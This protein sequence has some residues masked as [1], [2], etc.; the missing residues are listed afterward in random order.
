MYRSA[1]ERFARKLPRT[2][3]TSGKSPT[4]GGR[5]LE[6]ALRSS[7]RSGRLGLLLFSTIRYLI[8]YNVNKISDRGFV[9]M[10]FQDDVIALRRVMMTRVAMA[11]CRYEIMPQFIFNGRCIRRLLMVEFHRSLYD[12]KIRNEIYTNTPRV[13]RV[14]IKDLFNGGYR[15]EINDLRYHRTINELGKRDIQKHALSMMRAPWLRWIFKHLFVLYRQIVML[16]VDDGNLNVIIFRFVDVNGLAPRV[17]LAL[18]LL[19]YLAVFLGNLIVFLR[20]ARRDAIV[21]MVR[22]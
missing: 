4:A 19:R 15:R 21:T 12:F 3:A 1:L 16:F 14:A 11:L 18:V 2:V 10:L 13:S 17:R 20:D 22:T 7:Q 5:R 6:V 8:Y 9:P